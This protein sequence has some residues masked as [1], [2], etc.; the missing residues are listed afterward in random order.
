MA[1][2]KEKPGVQNSFDFTVAFEKYQYRHINPWKIITLL[3]EAR[4]N[5]AFFPLNQH[6]LIVMGGHGPE[7]YS[8]ECM[9]VTTYHE[10]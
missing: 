9:I 8:T 3:M 4:I 10:M 7:D 2:E 6:Q 1:S 5:P